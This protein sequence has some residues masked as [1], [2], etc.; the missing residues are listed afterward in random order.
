[1]LIRLDPL[2]ILHYNLNSTNGKKRPSRSHAYVFPAF[3]VVSQPLL[4]LEE[5]HI[6]TKIFSV[7]YSQKLIDHVRIT[8]RVFSPTEIPG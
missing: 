4:A 1:M 3:I 2:V 5:L 8:Q 6:D 7:Y